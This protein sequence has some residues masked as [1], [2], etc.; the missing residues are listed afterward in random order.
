M[1]TMDTYY[2]VLQAA[3][4]DSPDMQ[5]YPID[6]TEDGEP[7]IEMVAGK[8]LYN[9]GY[10]VDGEECECTFGLRLAWPDGVTGNPIVDGSGKFELYLS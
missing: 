6:I 1:N 3:I 4:K 10:L 5:V 2:T 7:A 9:F 8:P